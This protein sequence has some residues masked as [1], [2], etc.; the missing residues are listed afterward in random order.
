MKRAGILLVGFF[1]TGTLLAQD[2]H[3]SQFFASPLTLN[4]A[5]TGKFNGSFRLTGNHRNQW[6]TIN[7]AYITTA[8]SADFHVMQ[9]TIPNNDNWGVGFSG[10]ADRSANSAVSFNFASVSTAYHKGLDEDG[11]H[12]IGAGFQMSYAN[13]LINTSVLNFED[14]LT[15][16]GFTGISA[17]TFNGATLSS[18]YVDINAGFLYNG[19]TGDG[20]NFYL[21]VSMY[22]INRPKQNFTGG[23]YVLNPRTTIHGGAYFPI[24]PNATFHTSAIYM[25]QAGASETVV[26]GAIQLTANPDVEKPVSLYAGSWVRFNDALIPYLGLEF[27]DLRI[28]VSYDLNTSTLRTASLNRGGMEVSLIYVRRPSDQRPI[29]CP[30]F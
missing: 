29:K 22:H 2:P 16:N 1:I 6:P 9:N 18:R 30:K 26:G 10:Y 8:F 23:Q 25:M 28:G 3:F 11:N 24:S 17:E 20:N 5:L 14:Q 4:P 7:N 13:M 12:Q 21:G 19:S 15:A 27:N